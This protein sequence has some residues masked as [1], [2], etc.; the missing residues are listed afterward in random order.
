MTNEE[1]KEQI[2]A[3]EPSVTFDETGEWLNVQVEP[4]QWKELARGL[5]NSAM[6]FDYLFCLT[7]IDWKTHMTM[8]YHLSSTSHRHNI[9]VKAKVDRNQPEIE[10]VCDIWRTA[11]FHEREVFELFGVVFLNHPDLR[12]L[13]LTDDFEGFPL[14]K[15]FEDPI[16]MIKL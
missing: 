1:L 15:D 16:N 12:R 2:L 4:A 7:C 13:I 11:E 9:V 6:H 5:R 10:T 14:R 8:V 3:L